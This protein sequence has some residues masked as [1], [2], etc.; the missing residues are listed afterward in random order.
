MPGGENSINHMIKT[1][2]YNKGLLQKNNRFT[3][4]NSFF[5]TKAEYKKYR[6]ELKDHKTATPEQLQEIKQRV[7]RAQVKYYVMVALLGSVIL[8]GISGLGYYL[9]QIDV[10]NYNQYPVNPYEEIKPETERKINFYLTD[11]DLWLQ[12]H[13]W[14]NAYFQY[15]KALELDPHRKETNVKLAIY[16][17]YQCRFT[18]TNCA[19]GLAFIDSIS[20]HFPESP[21]LQQL[22]KSQLEYLQ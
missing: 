12:K 4:S 17:N 13:H 2:K 1:L 5:D 20:H 15:N 22:R 7:K 18:Q 8:S 6:S 9:W 16:Y 21:Q 11:G 3:K 19:Y 14:G 10:L